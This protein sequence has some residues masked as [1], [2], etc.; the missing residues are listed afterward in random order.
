MGWLQLVGSF[1]LQV[2]F[3]EYRLFNTALLQKRARPVIL[4]SLL[5]VAT[6]N[7]MYLGPACA[8]VL[9]LRCNSFLK[10]RI[11]LALSSSRTGC[12]YPHKNKTAVTTRLV[13]VYSDMG[14]LQLVGSIKLQVSFAKEPYKRDYILHKRLEVLPILL[15]VATPFRTQATRQA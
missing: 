15:T 10:W 13:V 9:H 1:K 4:R 8:R 11:S 12:L 5:I 7:Y 6:P 14:W 2:S 3:A